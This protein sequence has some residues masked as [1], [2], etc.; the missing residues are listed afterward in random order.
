MTQETHLPLDRTPAP[1]ALPRD[2]LLIMVAGLLSM[3]LWLTVVGQLVFLVPR[4][5]R[6]FG[7]FKMPLLTE[8]VI[9]DSR[10]AVPAVTIA[11]LLVCIALGKRSRWAWPFLLIL[12]PLIINVLVG[13]SLYFPY[14]EL[15]EGHGLSGG[16]K[17]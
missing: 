17:K 4:M 3:L 14:M 9:H 13:V 15:V 16:G 1:T 8:W 12:L 10:W 6:L 7:E 5:E 2:P 11:T